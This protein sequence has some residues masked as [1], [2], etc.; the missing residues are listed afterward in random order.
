MNIPINCARDVVGNNGV[1]GRG[2]NVK[3]RV[4][5]KYAI[6]MPVAQTYKC[7]VLNINTTDCN[8]ESDAV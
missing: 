3:I 7:N 1:L 4:A 6:N 2:E 8:N 5:D